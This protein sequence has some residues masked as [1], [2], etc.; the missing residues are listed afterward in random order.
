MRALQSA[1]GIGQVFADS[2]EAQRKQISY[3]EVQARSQEQAAHTATKRKPSAWQQA[4]D[5]LST[6]GAAQG[7]AAGINPAKTP[8][9]LPYAECRRKR[10]HD[11][12]ANGTRLRPDEADDG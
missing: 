5:S 2:A 9:T 1:G 11:H 7:I 12:N 10:R 6:G 8:K 4:K 3:Q